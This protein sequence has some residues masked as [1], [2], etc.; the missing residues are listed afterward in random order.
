ME[1]FGAASPRAILEICTLAVQMMTLPPAQADGAEASLLTQLSDIVGLV[2]TE[3]S[4]DHPPCQTLA[5]D[6]AAAVSGFLG[7]VDSFA[8][9]H[10]ALLSS[11]TDPGKR[12]RNAWAADYRTIFRKHFEL[13]SPNIAHR[14]AGAV[15]VLNI[16]KITEEKQS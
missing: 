7:A 1:D 2:S 9:G 4:K 14:K 12:W 10:R 11:Q 15:M 8:E 13:L 3:L 5:S 16:T 6:F